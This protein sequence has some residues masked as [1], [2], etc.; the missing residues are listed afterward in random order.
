MKKFI[1]VI[2][3]ALFSCEKKIEKKDIPFTNFVFSMSAQHSDYSMKFTNSDTVYFEKR[4]P[5]PKE[6]FYSIIQKSD[7]EF[8]TKIVSQINFSKYDSIYDEYKINHLVD[9]TGYKFYTE[10]KSKKNWIYI[11]GHTGP[12]E[13]YDF[14]IFLEHFK[15]KQQLHPTNKKIDFGNLNHILL[16][17][18]PEPKIINGH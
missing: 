3:I 1:I 5:D 9:G 2:F 11:Y 12:K 4:F 14:A 17:E 18:P 7:K 15:E 13:F 8:I 16:P 10:N 6:Y